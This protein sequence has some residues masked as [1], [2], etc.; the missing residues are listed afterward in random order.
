MIWRK[1]GLTRNASDRLKDSNVD[2]VNEVISP[3]PDLFQVN[4][5]NYIPETIFRIR[6]KK[7]R[8][9]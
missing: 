4:S 6:T 9:H 3:G 5:E 2:L 8:F 7:S 1:H